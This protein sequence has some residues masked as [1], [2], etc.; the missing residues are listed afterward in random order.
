MAMGISAFFLGVPS[1]ALAILLIW[2]IGLQL[3]LLPISGSSEPRHLILPMVVLSAEAIA[4]TIRQVRSAMLEQV[5]QDYVR[6]LRASGIPERR[7]IW[8][9]ALR[10]AIP[11]VV[12]ARRDPGRCATSSS[13]KAAAGS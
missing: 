6:T 11:P 7:V 2:L 5:D 13:A 3:R 10:N 1:F 9:H 8:V 4:V 12:A